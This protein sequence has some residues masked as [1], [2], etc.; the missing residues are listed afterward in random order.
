MLRADPV[1]PAKYYGVKVSNGVT[2][3]SGMLGLVSSTEPLQ[4]KAVVLAGAYDQYGRGQVSNFVRSFTLLNMNLDIDAQ[5][6]NSGGQQRLY[7]CRCPP[8]GP[9]RAACLAERGAE[10][11]HSAFY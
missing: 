8:A 4:V 10:H 2:V 5:R 11:P 9:A 6:L 1:D 3:A 7:R